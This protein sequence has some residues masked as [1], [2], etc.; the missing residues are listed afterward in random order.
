MRYGTR[1]GCAR[2]DRNT[3]TCG[4]S[5]CRKPPQSKRPVL[6]SPA[7]GVPAQ[8][9]HPAASVVARQ[10]AVREARSCENLSSSF[11]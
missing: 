2:M 11:G 3:S 5:H 10:G 9:A 7:S 1:R 6:P 8:R 4:C